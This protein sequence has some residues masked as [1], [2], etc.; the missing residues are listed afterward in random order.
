MLID[1]TF[2][3][4]NKKHL[5]GLCDNCGT[6]F[7]RELS[8]ANKMQYCSTK[9]MGKGRTKNALK[10]Y[11]CENCTKV[12]TRANRSKKNRFC[13]PDCSIEFQANKNRSLIT[14]KYCT[15]TLIT[16]NS[17][18]CSKKCRELQKTK[19]FV[20]L[21]TEFLKRPK[22]DYK[23]YLDEKGRYTNCVICEKTLENLYAQKLFCGRVCRIV[24]AE[25]G[26][27]YTP[28]FI[29]KECL[30]CGETFQEKIGTADR[31][32][33]KYCTHACYLKVNKKA[34]K[35]FVSLLNDDAVVFH[36]SWELRFAATCMRFDIPCR[37]YDGDPI[38][39]TAGDYYPDFIVG[40]NDDIIEIKGYI[41]KSAE[42]KI[43][44]AHKI[45]GDR[46]KVLLEEDLKKFEETGELV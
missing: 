10:D 40:R 15:K 7:D 6:R 33:K 19:K 44:T 20:D 16:T 39:T 4:N 2:I 28:I 18:Y 22:D 1:E 12:F 17:R 37:R 45:L 36:S 41:E 13:S 29:D 3:K 34:G 5:V 25:L 38:S 46:Y 21:K 11:N 30:S 31:L 32:Q 9:C 35:R 8:Y 24:G 14:C 23:K 26:I 43:E 42:V 27:R